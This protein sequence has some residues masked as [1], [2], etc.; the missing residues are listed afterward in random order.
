M[1]LLVFITRYMDLFT[2]FISIYN[3]VFKVLF[4]AATAYI[5]FLIKFKRP[6][7]I[8]YDSKTD[9]FNHYLFLYPPVLVVTIL[10]HLGNPHS[11][12]NYEYLWS[13]SVWLEAVAIV[14][15]LWIVYKK[16]EVSLLGRNHHWLLYGLSRLL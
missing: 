15:Q 4:I 2:R 16:R 8:G 1:Y 13:F 10:F 6:F 5:I 14:P 11:Y 12:L 7:C 9:S 3:T